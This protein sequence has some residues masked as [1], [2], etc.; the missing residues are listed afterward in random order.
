[1]IKHCDFGDLGRC[2]TNVNS[3]ISDVQ[4][5]YDETQFEDGE[6]HGV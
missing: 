6:N 1:M 2:Q 4:I 3:D 5:V